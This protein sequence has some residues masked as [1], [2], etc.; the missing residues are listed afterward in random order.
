MAKKQGKN[1]ITF[2]DLFAGIGGFHLA[3][4]DLGAKCVFVSEWNEHARKTYEHNFKK[5]DP[6]IFKENKFAGDITEIV[7]SPKKIREN[8]PEF[9]ILTGGFP[10][11]PFSNAGYKKGFK[12]PRGTLFYDVVKILK[13]MRPPAFFL[14]NVRHLYNHDNGETFKTIK[15]VLENELGYTFKEKIVRA[16]DF[17][18]PQHRPRLFMVGFDKK[19]FGDVDFQFPDSIDRTMTMSDIF[20]EKCS[21]DIGFTLRVGGRG[22]SIEDRRNWDA[23][24]VGNKIVRLTPETGKKMMG[25]PE[26]YEFPVSNVQA[27]KQLGNAVAVPAIRA[28][29]EKIIET[30]H[31]NGYKK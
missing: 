16:S 14:E 9:D 17:G 23:Y 21:R 5:I 27:M 13:E 30:L 22:S 31:K 7:E 19:R 11:Q 26:D 10:C 29:A 28:T 2:I 4:H 8:I 12:D 24:L 15:N 20:G 3:L 6:S 1:Q 25:F 18:L